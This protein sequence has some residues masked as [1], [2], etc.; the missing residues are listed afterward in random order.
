MQAAP[1]RMLLP[2][3]LCVC[4]HPLSSLHVNPWHRGS[5]RQPEASPQVKLQ[6][7]APV[8]RWPQ[9]LGF[10]TWSSMIRHW[11]H[12]GPTWRACDQAQG[13][14]FYHTLHRLL[15]FLRSWFFI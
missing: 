12:C 11:R 4:T 7:P 3:L 10:Q 1:P 8:L 13:D 2:Y 9:E 14:C 15:N 6:P 5:S